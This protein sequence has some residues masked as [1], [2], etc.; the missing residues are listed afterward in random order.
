MEQKAGLHTWAEFI[1][2]DIDAL[3][4]MARS[5]ED[6]IR[7]LQRIGWQ[8]KWKTKDGSRYLKHY[9]VRPP[10]WICNKEHNM[11]WHRP[12]VKCG[13]GY[14]REGLELRIKY[15]IW[16]IEDIDVPEE[17]SFGRYRRFKVVGVRPK[18]GTF[19]R[20]MTDYQRTKPRDATR[21]SSSTMAKL[22]NNEGFS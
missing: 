17:N 14:S 15:G 18:N 8:V 3:L 13:Y 6:V 22:S 21:M 7:G 9:A 12:D 10:K 11:A 16:D 20:T 19:R 4:P 1:A 2:A 5:Y